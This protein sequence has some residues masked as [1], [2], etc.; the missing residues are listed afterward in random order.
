MSQFQNALSEAWATEVSQHARAELYSAMWGA[1]TSD[2]EFYSQHNRGIHAAKLM[3]SGAKGQP[4]K[5]PNPPSPLANLKHPHGIDGKMAKK[6]E[7]AAGGRESAPEQRLLNLDPPN[8][9][10]PVQTFRQPSSTFLPT[11]AQK[12][13][14]QGQLAFE[15]PKPP[16]EP[17]GVALGG[18]PY[19]SKDPPEHKESLPGQLTLFPEN[20]K[21][22][23]V[24]KPT[25]VVEK[26]VPTPKPQPVSQPE[27]KPPVESTP[28]KPLTDDE[29]LGK[30]EGLIKA[31]AL[32]HKGVL[33][34]EE[35]VQR[36]RIV[37]WQ[38][39]P[40]FDPS[41][42]L[43]MERYLQTK[44][45]EE[46][47]NAQRN[48]AAKKRGGAGTG[49]KP[50]E[51][52]E[53]SSGLGDI[54]KRVASKKKA[55][56]LSDLASQE[57]KE[58]DIPGS[59]PA[60]DVAMQ[61]KEKQSATQ[62]FVRDMISE[63]Y[64]ESSDSDKKA[65]HT[66][67]LNYGIYHPTLNPSG[68]QIQHQG[69]LAKKLDLS[70]NSV[71][72]HIG[73][74]EK[75]LHRRLG[76]ARKRYYQIV[77]SAD[78]ERF[79]YSLSGNEPT[80]FQAALQDAWV[81]RYAGEHDP[82]VFHDPLPGAFGEAQYKKAPKKFTETGK[83]AGIHTMFHPQMEVPHHE[84]MALYHEKEASKSEG[85]AKEAHNQYA[86]IHRQAAAKKK[87]RAFV[88][89]KKFADMTAAEHDQQRKAHEA[90]AK[91]AT[92]SHVRA[93]HEQMAKSHA[94]MRDKKLAQERQS[95]PAQ[96]QPKSPTSQPPEQKS[97]RSTP[98]PEKEPQA[99]PVQREPSWLE[100]KAKQLKEAVVG[101]PAT[102]PTPEQE[103]V[104][105]LT[106]LET[107]HRALLEPHKF[108]AS[109]KGD[110]WGNPH[111]IETQ[112]L[113]DEYH[114]QPNATNRKTAEKKLAEAEQFHKDRT[115]N[116]LTQMAQHAKDKA[117]AANDLLAQDPNNATGLKL[118]AQARD[119]VENHIKRQLDH[120][121]GILQKHRDMLANPPQKPGK[122]PKAPKEEDA[123]P[124]VDLLRQAGAYI[125]ALKND[126]TIEGLATEAAKREAKDLFQGFHGADKHAYQDLI[127][128][129]REKIV[130]EL[131]K[132]AGDN[133][134]AAREHHETVSGSEDPIWDV[135]GKHE[136][137][138]K[139]VDKHREKQ[140][141]GAKQ[142]DAL[143]TAI[144]EVHKRQSQEVAQYNDAWRNLTSALT[145]G[146]SIDAAKLVNDARKADDADQIP[147]FDELVDMVRRSPE[148][149]AGV[150]KHDRGQGS[151][152]EPSLEE[153]VF[154]ALKHGGV[155]PMPSRNDPKIVNEAMDY[156]GWREPTTPD[157]GEQ[158]Q[159][160]E[161]EDIPFS[162][163]FD[164]DGSVDLYAAM[165]DAWRMG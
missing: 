162:A 12:P 64:D 47:L 31:S 56:S 29:F 89:G 135:I 76:K 139:D 158:E 46:L 120:S 23:P 144:D 104:R 136:Q 73:R 68:E 164:Q 26:P 98:A 112:R 103:K 54:V 153:A 80:K 79:L 63:M 124:A 157:S 33:E 44:I 2:C 42:G 143:E 61:S 113:L 87:E 92:E 88:P 50:T 133:L 148:Q 71:S 127:P 40:K 19:F 132:R 32:L 49:K 159:P 161:Q 105:K 85:I 154:Q 141:L 24:A 111:R 15:E 137:S 110:N 96:P 109:L 72:T 60:P 16:S 53:Q 93:A 82:N 13:K 67:V 117:Q 128:E 95:A 7:Y 150:L 123:K 70:Q 77:T 108:E 35:A 115:L 57:G 45:K 131:K 122:Q 86:E 48:E 116:A 134:K 6:I 78:F 97:Q 156:M 129:H 152:Q 43:S 9:V 121:E 118:K 119:L 100:R 146:R 30:H 126:K 52:T 69:E 27:V 25:P 18:R 10:T 90:H 140:M 39:R 138:L 106:A 20:K 21:E 4:P 74:I 102:P 91:D 83:Q 55:A 66:F 81:E 11:Q 28:E 58:Y 65:L 38:A 5:A 145:K 51:A 75:L 149:Y 160:K 59:T 151:S 99:P 165:Y 14:V 142:E 147:H 125:Q 114:A 94:G 101:K 3:R 36:A 22:T 107:K 1:W 34:P 37:A 130:A 84:S 41:H 62:K 17:I 8:P 155:K 163:K